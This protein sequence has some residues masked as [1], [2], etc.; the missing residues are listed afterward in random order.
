MVDR[1]ISIVVNGPDD[2]SMALCIAASLTE[3][4]KFDAIDIM[5]RFC[6]WMDDGYECIDVSRLFA[7]MLHQALSGGAKKLF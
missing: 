2:T 3:M 6:R 4:G 1:S 7:A 5:N